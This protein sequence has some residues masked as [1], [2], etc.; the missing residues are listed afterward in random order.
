MPS[1]TCY[2]HFVVRKLKMNFVI[3][4]VSSRVKI[5]KSAFAKYTLYYVI[6]DILHV[7]SCALELY[8][9]IKVFEILVKRGVIHIV[10]SFARCT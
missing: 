1:Y 8:V 4:K 2:H 3:R 10:S 5:S 9:E 7:K 6:Y